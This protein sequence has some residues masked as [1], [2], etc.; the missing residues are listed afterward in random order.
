MVVRSGVLRT[1][2][3]RPDENKE[4]KEEKQDRPAKG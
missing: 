2:F 1:T 3:Q 4:K